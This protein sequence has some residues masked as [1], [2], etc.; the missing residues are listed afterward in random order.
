M[1]VGGHGADHVD[2]LDIEHFGQRAVFGHAEVALHVADG[3]GGQRGELARQQPGLVRQCVGGHGIVDDAECGGLGAGD[4]IGGEV[5]LARFRRAD[6]VGQEIAAAIVARRADFGE[7]RGQLGAVRGDAHVAGECDRQAGTGGGA[8]DH[9]ERRLGHVVED[10]RQIHAVAQTVDARVEA[11]CFGGFAGVGV[12][13]D[14]AF[15]VAA[16]AERPAGAGDDHQPHLGIER[17][18]LRGFGQRCEHARGQRVARLRPVH[19]QRGNAVFK[20]LDDFVGQFGLPG[21]CCVRLCP[22][23]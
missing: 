10:T 12:A 15:D 4:D 20:G 1:I 2:C 22:Q 7:C 17:E 11:W 5:E 9:G 8:G 16:G 3:D 18:A 14:E 6:E 19:G 23:A 21:C 13:C